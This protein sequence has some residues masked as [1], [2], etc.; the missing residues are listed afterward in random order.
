MASSDALLAGGQGELEH[1]GNS[2]SDVVSHK[3]SGLSI[4]MVMKLKSQS[5]KWKKMSHE[6]ALDHA[7]AIGYRCP[8]AGRA[9]A[10]Q[11]DGTEQDHSADDLQTNMEAITNLLNNCLGSGVLAVAFAISKAGLVVGGLMLVASCLLNRFSLMLLADSCR[12]AN[13]DVSYNEI[14]RIALGPPGRYL[15]MAIFVCMGFGCLV[16]YLDA[17]IDATTG[18]LSFFDIT[19]TKPTLLFFA[20]IMNI[21]PTFLRS[22]KSVALL[23]GI[24]FVGALVVVACAIIQC[25]GG[26]VKNGLP[27][28]EQLQF[29]PADTVTFLGQINI[30]SITFCIQAGG[31]IVISTLKDGSRENQ[32]K[33]TGI[34]FAIAFLVNFVVGYLAYLCY[35]DKVEGDVVNAFD[36]SA[37]STLICKIALLDLVVLSY[38]FMMIPCRVAVL[39]FAFNKNE[40]HQEAS[41]TQF[42]GVTLIINLLAIGVAFFVSDVGVVVSINGAISANVVA[43]I[44][45]ALIHIFISSSKYAIDKQ[46]YKPKV[47]AANAPF[48]AMII[49]GLFCMVTG[50]MTLFGV[51]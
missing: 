1:G 2:S 47:C 5:K 29:V 26:L 10:K 33:V 50:L 6:H 31:S 34:G 43:W 17:T 48:F 46:Q 16:S 20:A 27:S 14:G 15:V 25:G 4:G 12:L 38:M 45:P 23:S 13:I 28:T 22:L 32:S 9:A 7:M 18:I 51:L 37:I 41:W 44:L 11:G 24:A 21:P 19:L 35:T 36:P 8:Q 49:F 39:A 42:A 30:F 40:A 3:S